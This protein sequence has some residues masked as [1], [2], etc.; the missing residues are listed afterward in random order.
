M[1]GV[2]RRRQER[3]DH[4]PTHIVPR[5]NAPHRAVTAFNISHNCA[6]VDKPIEQNGVNYRLAL[7]E[8]KLAFVYVDY[9]LG[10][11]FGKILTQ[12]R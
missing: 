5:P 4:L 10:V 12:K 2:T 7:L 1:G 8:R 11:S 3:I 9:H 6:N